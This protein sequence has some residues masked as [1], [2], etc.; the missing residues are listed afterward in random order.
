[1]ATGIDILVQP[2]SEGVFDISLENG[3]LVGDDGFDTSLALSLLTDARAD[4]SQVAVPEKRRGWVGD[5]VS[6]VENR[7]LGGLLWLVEQRR[8]THDNL[9]TAVDLAQKSL[10]WMVDDGVLQD[11]SISGEIEVGL[12]ISLTIITTYLDGKTESHYVKLWENT[13]A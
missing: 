5:L 13:G 12:G 4:S 7:S 10:Q 6:P 8:L 9:N 1:M 3:D 2:D 11:V